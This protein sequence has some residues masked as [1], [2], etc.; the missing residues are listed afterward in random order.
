MSL[1]HFLN[2]DKM[3]NYKNI[4]LQNYSNTRSAY[5]NYSNN[6]HISTGS[7]YVS[8]LDAIRARFDTLNDYYH[9]DE[10]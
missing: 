9:I 3:K 4:N 2:S 7:I 8:Q 6:N 1:I 10:S 5:T